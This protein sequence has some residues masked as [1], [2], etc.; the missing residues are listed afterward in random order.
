MESALEVLFQ[1][2]GGNDLLPSVQE[3]AVCLGFGLIKN[4]PMVD[5]NK[6]IGTHAMLMLLSLNEI[7]LQYSQKELYEIIIGVA[8]DE[9]SYEDLLK[10]VLVHEK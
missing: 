5:G 10:W 9:K 3:K 1:A 6:R 8:A 2:F 4:H 7:E